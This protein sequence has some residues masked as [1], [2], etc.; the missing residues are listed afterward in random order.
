MALSAQTYDAWFTT[1]PTTHEKAGQT[2]EVV[3]REWAEAENAR[4]RE[5]VE[6]AHGS[7]E[8]SYARLCE[9]QQKVVR[10]RGALE[11]ARALIETAEQDGYVNAGWR[12]DA[13]TWQECWRNA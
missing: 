11:E 7:A 12:E 8:V 9:E 6:K 1:Y 10:L 2:V 13:R 5:T 3:T 4:L